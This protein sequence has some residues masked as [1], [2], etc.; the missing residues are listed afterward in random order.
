MSIY[1]KLPSGSGFVKFEDG[2]PQTLKLVN[3]EVKE[4]DP[5]KPQ[6]NADDGTVM[7][8]EF[9]TVDGEQKFFTRKSLAGF[10]MS[11]EKE[12]VEPGDWVSI[13]RTGAGAD[14]RY[15]MH[16]L[17]PEEV[18]LAVKVGESKEEVKIEEVPF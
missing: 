14:T 10:G 8:F 13:T 16:K 17:T 5:A 9:E 1:D 11:L 6:F 18:L 4:G 3:I 2:K 15:A 7:E 12:K